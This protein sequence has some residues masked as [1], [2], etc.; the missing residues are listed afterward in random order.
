MKKIILTISFLATVLFSTMQAQAQVSD[1]EERTGK[2]ES[3]I[4]KLPKMSG[5]INLRYQYE[6]GANSF[7]IRRARLDFKGEPAK[8]FDYRLQLDFA[9]SP[10]IIDAFVRLKLHPMF[11]VQAGQFKVAFSLENPYG[12]LDLETIENS[13]VVGYLSGFNDLAGNKATGR[14]IGVAAYGGFFQQD[15]YNIVDYFVGLYNGTGIN[16]KD[17]NKHK[18]FA[19]RININPIRP[20]TLSAFYYN[21]KIGPDGELAPRTRFGFGARYDDGKILFRGEYIKGKTNQKDSDGFYL[22]AG[23]TIADKFQPLFK[24]DYM[25]LDLADENSR[26]INYLVGIDYWPHKMFRL[27]VN[28]TFRTFIKKEKTSGMLGIMLTARF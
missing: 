19:G 9:S 25:R 12:P 13:Q 24:Y 16:V 3:I 17:N 2:L 10:K 20:V 4:A 28:Y 14:D 8:W 6:D 23:Y 11:N 15:G 21:G 1:L 5:F 7:D 26:Q 18:D 22:L 27:Q